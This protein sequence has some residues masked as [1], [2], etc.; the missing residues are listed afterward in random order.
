MPILPIS[1]LCGNGQLRSRTLTTQRR[2]LPYHL[3]D[4]GPILARA[5]Q[6]P[7]RVPSPKRHGCR[8]R[9]RAEVI[10]FSRAR[11]RRRLSGGRRRALEFAQ[12]ARKFPTSQTEL[13]T[14][15]AEEARHLTYD[16]KKGAKV[17]YRGT[18]NDPERREREHR[19]DGLEFD[20][21]VPTSRRMTR[22]GA[23]DREAQN[24]DR[25][26][27]NHGGRNPRYNKDDDG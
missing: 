22:R 26:R 5:A 19:Q 8:E 24:L 12:T 7:G 13:R 10:D 6:G 2:K 15:H 3:S 14:A 9:Q 4:L 17:V 11:A 27:R 25:Y 23:R 16:L 20:Q 1:A 18:T 21:L